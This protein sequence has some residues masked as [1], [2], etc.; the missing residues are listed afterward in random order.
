[1]DVTFIAW[2]GLVAG[3]VALLLLDLLVLHRGTQ[4]V[5]LRSAA[6]SSAVFVAVAIAFGIVLSAVE[7]HHVGAQFFAG[8]LLELSLSLD[9]VFVWA[10]ILSAF[11]IP[12][13]TSDF[14]RPSQLKKISS[15]MPIMR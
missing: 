7:S 10:L 14:G 15:P 9:N 3:L 5:S 12:A 1:M 4:E 11:S 13:A 2:A 6:W 8:Y